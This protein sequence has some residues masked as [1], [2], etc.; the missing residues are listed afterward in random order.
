MIVT[1]GLMIVLSACQPL[2]QRR[3]D[4]PPPPK[5]EDIEITTTE[6]VHIPGDGSAPVAGINAFDNPDKVIT[7]TGVGEKY[8]VQRGQD[9]NIIYE[10]INPEE[11]YIIF[12]STFDGYTLELAYRDEPV[13]LSFERLCQIAIVASPALTT[14]D[15]PKTL[16][17]EQIIWTPRKD[18]TWEVRIGTTERGCKSKALNELQ[19]LRTGEYEKNVPK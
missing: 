15:L 14:I 7:F 12:E 16:R 4:A 11:T 5:M 3:Y 2:T 19:Q 18:G 1:V 17:Y 10:G 9:V 8:E 6:S 13:Y